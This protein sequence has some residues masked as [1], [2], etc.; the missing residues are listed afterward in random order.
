MKKRLYEFIFFRLM[1]WKITGANNLNVN[2][3]V[4]MVLPHTSWHDFYLG[5]FT[6]GIT[7][8][9]MHFV[10][11]KELF[12]FPFGW[13]FKW[14]GGKPLDR[15][16][17]LNKVDAI[18]KTFDDYDELR[19]AIAPEG[20]RKLVSELKTGFYYIALK[21]NVPILPVAFD[22]GK[23][24]VKIGEPFIATGNYLEDMNQVLPF[25]DGVV[26]KIPQR[27]FIR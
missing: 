11:K 16:G 23:K 14:M 25:Y 13:Y 4:F 12:K 9:P 21:A 7:E 18:A 10:G 26:G 1:G 2:K 8:V 3:C 19:L 5:L 6:R 24:E 27:Q 20:T 22:F 17:G 15:T